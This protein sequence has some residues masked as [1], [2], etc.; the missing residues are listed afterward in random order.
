MGETPALWKSQKSHTESNHPWQHFWTFQTTNWEG[1]PTKLILPLCNQFSK[2]PQKYFCF[3]TELY[4]V[5]HFILVHIH[6]FRKL[7][8]NEWLVWSCSSSLK[9][10]QTR[11]FVFEFCT[12]ES[13]P[14][15]H[16]TWFFAL[17]G[18]N[19][20]M[21][22]NTFSP[23]SVQTSSFKQS[24]D[25]INWWWNSSWK[26]SRCYMDKWRRLQSECSPRLLPDPSCKG[27]I[28]KQKKLSYQHSKLHSPH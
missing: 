16:W 5:I 24:H 28:P 19:L 9:V 15:K 23:N 21:D 27:K 3:K 12:K 4:Q 20:S 22:R 6:F 25:V 8:T 13:I 10:F 26:S 14:L 2:H 17:S 11:K 1:R 18:Y 7:T